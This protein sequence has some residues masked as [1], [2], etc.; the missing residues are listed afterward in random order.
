MLPVLPILQIG[1]PCNEET[2]ITVVVLVSQP[3]SDILIMGADKR[4]KAVKILKL[5][6]VL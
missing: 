6:S 2:T 4:P 5:S 1:E 3:H